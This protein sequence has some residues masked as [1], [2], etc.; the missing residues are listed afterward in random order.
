M[1]YAYHYLVFTVQKK[2][3]NFTDKS[4][5]QKYFAMKWFFRPFKMNAAASANDY[6][7]GVSTVDVKDINEIIIRPSSNSLSCEKISSV[8]RVIAN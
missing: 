8:E 6:S 4:C 5:W 3:Q 7:K 1:C 2:C